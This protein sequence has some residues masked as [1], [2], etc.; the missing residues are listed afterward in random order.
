MK[1]SHSGYVAGKDFAW[2]AGP[3][4]NFWHEMSTGWLGTH[5]KFKENLLCL[6]QEARTF[7]GSCLHKQN[8]IFLHSINIPY[9]KKNPKITLLVI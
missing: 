3:Y 5:E 7:Y 9:K 6:L 8:K 2:K 4:V 1:P